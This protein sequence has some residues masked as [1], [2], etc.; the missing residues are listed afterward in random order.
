M[1]KYLVIDSSGVP[2][3]ESLLTASGI[4]PSVQGFELIAEKNG[5]DAL[6]TARTALVIDGE[7]RVAF[8]MPKEANPDYYGTEPLK[9][10]RRE[11]QNA[12]ITPDFKIFDPKI[13]SLGTLSHYFN[14]AV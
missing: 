5:F 8:I 4:S 1:K 11:L 10:V 9:Y 2:D 12:N 3:Y 6:S 7:N 14:F 13:E